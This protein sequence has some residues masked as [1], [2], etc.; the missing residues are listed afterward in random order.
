MDDGDLCGDVGEVD[1]QARYLD[2]D[3]FRRVVCGRDEPSGVQ[4]ACRTNDAEPPGNDA[5]LGPDA[6]DAKTAPHSTDV[7]NH[8]PAAPLGIF[9]RHTIDETDRQPELDARINA[10]ESSRCDADDLERLATSLDRP[11]DD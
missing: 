7:P 4:V 2:A 6:G 3:P 5:E 11:S 8:A 9:H 1:S 10:C